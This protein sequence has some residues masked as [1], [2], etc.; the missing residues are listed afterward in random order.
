MDRMTDLLSLRDPD[1]KPS[2]PPAAIAAAGQFGYQ[3]WF[4]RGAYVYVGVEE[5]FPGSDVGGEGL[6]IPGWDIDDGGWVGIVPAFPPFGGTADWGPAGWLG[7]S[8]RSPGRE[9]MDVTGA[10]RA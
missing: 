3:Y 10:S 8:L 2:G 4:V 7:L 6:V 1:A 9:G 5:N